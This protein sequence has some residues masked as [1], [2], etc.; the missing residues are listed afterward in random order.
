MPATVKKVKG[1][2]QVRTP[3]Q[4]HAKKTTKEKAE[5]QANLLRAVEHGWKP[6]GKKKGRK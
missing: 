5:S 2:Y 4:V 3:S 6:T 1:G